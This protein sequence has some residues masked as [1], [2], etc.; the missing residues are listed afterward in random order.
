MQIDDSDNKEQNLDKY[1]G[2]IDRYIFLLLVFTFF[3]P[4]KESNRPSNLDRGIK[5][6]T[7]LIYIPEITSQRIANFISEFPGK[8]GLKL[9]KKILYKSS[10]RGFRSLFDFHCV[11]SFQY[12]DHQLPLLN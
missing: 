1:E 11:Y 10:K 8:K 3:P 5:S 4:Q 6:L 9:K 12:N 7:H 2:K